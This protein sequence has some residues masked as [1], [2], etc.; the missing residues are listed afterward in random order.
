MFFCTKTKRKLLSLKSL[1]G[2]HF[3]ACISNTC[4]KNHTIVIATETTQTKH[5]KKSFSKNS[6]FVT[7]VISRNIL[8]KILTHIYFCLF[9]APFDDRISSSRCNNAM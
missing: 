6:T 1:D 4:Y 8:K 3:I 7:L 9:G 5:K 2:G